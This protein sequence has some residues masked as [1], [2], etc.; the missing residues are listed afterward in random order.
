M[1]DLR[2]TRKILRAWGAWS[3]NNVDC[4]WYKEA[5]GMSNVIPQEPKPYRDTISDED[6]LAVDKIVMLM[7]DED[8]PRPMTFFILSYV[9]GMNNCEIARRATKA[10]KKKCSEGKV[11]SALMLMET[12]V[13]GALTAQSDVGLSVG[14]EVTE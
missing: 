13:Q 2:T 12:F 3:S 14:F 1:R 5:P 11:R 8:N 7:H 6:A 10:D 9:Y 4:D